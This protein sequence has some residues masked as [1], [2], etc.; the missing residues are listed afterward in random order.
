MKGTIEVYTRYLAKDLDSRGTTVNVLTPGS[1]ETD[2]NN[3]SIRNN[4][5][6]KGSLAQSTALGRVGE[7]VD[8]GKII[9]FL[10][11]D[12]SKWIN[13]QRIEASGGMKL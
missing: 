12:D 10:C 8:I 7:S 3:A 1:V 6:M 11:S 4:P 2:F 5:Q 9:P 13:G